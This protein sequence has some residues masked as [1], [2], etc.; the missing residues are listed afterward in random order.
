MNDDEEFDLAAAM[1]AERARL[2]SQWARLRCESKGKLFSLVCHARTGAHCPMDER[3]GMDDVQAA[4]ALLGVVRQ[5]SA[6]HQLG[7][8]LRR[9]EGA[10]VIDA[11]QA[12]DWSDKNP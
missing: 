12:Q 2:E 6:T 11:H 10:D 4:A 7:E 3:I 8:Y 9:L 5:C 1:D